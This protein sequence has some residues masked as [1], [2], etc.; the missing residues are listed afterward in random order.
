MTGGVAVK[1]QERVDI[2]AFLL[3]LTDERVRFERAPFDHP[4]IC[5]PHGHPEREPGVL[6]PDEGSPGAPIA[7]DS[8]VLV[9]AVG[10]GGADV[11]LQTF[12]ELLRGIGNDGSRA[13]TMTTPCTTT[14]AAPPGR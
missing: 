11:P 13:H 14:T 1:A 12:D 5:V 3:S 10:S 7:A 8:M 2:L 4:S 9:P 6:V